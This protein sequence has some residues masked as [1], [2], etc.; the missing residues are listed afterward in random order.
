MSE[1]FALNFDLKQKELIAAGFSNPLDAY[2]KLYD[3]LNDNYSKR[4]QSSLIST[5]E[6]ALSD[7]FDHIFELVHSLILY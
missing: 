1:R 4:Q 3:F 7:V 2:E 6:E 5:K